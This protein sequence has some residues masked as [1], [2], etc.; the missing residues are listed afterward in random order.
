M[1]EFDLED[2]FSEIDFRLYINKFMRENENLIN[3]IDRDNK[4][5]EEYN[6]S[7]F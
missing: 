2:E 4:L 1:D 5:L 6:S 7:I 3:S